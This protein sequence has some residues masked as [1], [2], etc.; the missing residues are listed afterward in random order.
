MSDIEN[1]KSHSNLTW[2][3]YNIQYLNKQYLINIQYLTCEIGVI[4][5]L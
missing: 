5:W 4:L 2:E 3:I 1:F